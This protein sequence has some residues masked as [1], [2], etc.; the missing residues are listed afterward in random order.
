MAL[1]LQHFTFRKFFYFLT[2][3]KQ[4]TTN[5]EPIMGT[6][7][8]IQVEFTPGKSLAV[9]AHWDGYPSHMGRMLLNHYNTKA[10]A[11][12]LISHGDLSCV[13]ASCKKPKG[14]THDNPVKGYCIYYGRDR[15]ETEDNIQ[16]HVID[17]FKISHIKQG[18]EFQYQFTKGK[19]FVD[20][21]TGN[22]EML[23]ER[24]I[25]EHDDY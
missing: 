23:T 7:S 3:N 21:N 18:Q 22:W 1:S 9:Y 25:L 13:Y 17:T 6:R 12:E 10:K 15:G 4:Q 16:P 11:L 2:D 20:H 8:N 14:H 19:W 24:Y 5:K